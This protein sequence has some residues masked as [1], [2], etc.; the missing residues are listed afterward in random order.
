MGQ[1]LA[2]H[3]QHL[4][5]RTRGVRGS[6]LQRMRTLRIVQ[7][8]P[9]MHQHRGGMARADDVEQQ[10][11]II[12]PQRL[13]L[14]IALQHGGQRIERHRA[15]RQEL[16]HRHRRLEYQGRVDHVAEIQ[17]S[18]DRLSRIDQQIARVAVAMNGLTA[19]AAKPRLTAAKGAGHP[20]HRAAQRRG[21]DGAA[22]FHEF[23]E[24]PHVPGQA[25]RQR[26]MKKSLQG[27]VE[28]CQGGTQ[29]SQQGGAGRRTGQELPGQI[30]HQA[31][32]VVHPIAT[33]T[34][35]RLPVQGGEQPRHRQ[36]GILFGQMIEN[37]YQAVAA[38]GVGGEILDFEHELMGVGRSRR[39]PAGTRQIGGAQTEIAVPFPG[40][41]TG[42]YRQPIRLASDALAFRDA[43][44]LR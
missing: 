24:T 5:Q 43:K 32:G 36:A 20:L 18:A 28:P 17:N 9:G 21:F 42:G 26:G 25:P 22:E 29:V 10:F 35:Q 14:R 11:D 33:E 19:Q 37:R 23:A 16:G 39:V 31:G 1:G 40:K 4:K 7:P 27:T 2:I 6:R 38:V 15:L 41:G 30:A 34:A 12:A 13:A 3:A 44:R 8:A